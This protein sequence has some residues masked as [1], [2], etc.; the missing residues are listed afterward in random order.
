MAHWFL[1]PPLLECTELVSI[2]RHLLL[3]IVVENKAQHI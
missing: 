3:N 2:Q 1:E